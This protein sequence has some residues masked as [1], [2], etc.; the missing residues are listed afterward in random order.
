MHIYD[1]R[2]MFHKYCIYLCIFK[3]SMATSQKSQHLNC[4]EG[5]HPHRL[6]FAN[7]AVCVEGLRRLFSSQNKGCSGSMFTVR[8]LLL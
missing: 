1:V 3:I 2:Y 5:G 8:A 4:P 6:Q 7:V